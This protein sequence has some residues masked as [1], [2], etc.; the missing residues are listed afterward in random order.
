[1]DSKKTLELC[2]HFAPR[3]DDYI[4]NCR[5]HGPE[6]L[7]GLMYSCLRPGQKVLDLGTGTGLCAEVFKRLDLEIYGTDGSAE[8]LKRCEAKGLTAGLELYDLAGQGPLPFSPVQFHHILSH[9]VFHMLYRLDGL[10]GR[11]K[12]RLKPGGIFA[13]TV[14]PDVPASDNEPPFEP[15]GEAGIYSRVNGESGLE[16]FRHSGCYIEETL[17]GC[18][19]RLLKV[20]LYQAFRDPGDGREVFFR[21][22]V[23]QKDA[24]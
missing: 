10:F 11:V 14:E 5:W 4:Q 8:M 21:A 13:F 18:G 16:Q 19:L 22:Y 20:L 2:D 3:Y 23:T 7:F 9:G 15:R 24:G 6:V 17:K 12:E 1:M